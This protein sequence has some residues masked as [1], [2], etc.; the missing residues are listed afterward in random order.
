MNI[1][2]S[3]ILLAGL[4][5]A[6][7]AIFLFAGTRDRAPQQTGTTAPVAVIQEPDRISARG[8][9]FASTHVDLPGDSESYPSGP[10]A[11]T[12]NANCLACHSASMVLY[13]P[14][15]TAA[16]WRKEVEKMRDAYGAPITDADIPAIV[17][18]LSAMRES[19]RK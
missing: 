7:V 15:L 5:L 14:S 9:T 4:G 2:R 3:T 17:A 10:H 12:V 13:Q 8:L 1:S 6:A 19:R 11:D 16:E 18:Y